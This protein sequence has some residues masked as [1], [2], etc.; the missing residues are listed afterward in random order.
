MSASDPEIGKSVVA[1]G[2]K[3]NYLEA[4]AGEE[5][6]RAGLSPDQFANLRDYSTTLEAVERCGISTTLPNISLLLA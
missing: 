6:H 5:S 4:G 1:A 2:L 3:T